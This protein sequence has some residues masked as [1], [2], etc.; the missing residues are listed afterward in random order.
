MASGER[1]GA[2]VALLSMFASGCLAVAKVTIGLY[3]GSTAVVA[4][5]VESASDVLASGI[6]IFGLTLASRPADENHPY[7]HGR[8][9]T[10]TGL[11]LGVILAVT[12]LLIC[13]RSAAA[14]R[15]VRPPPASFVVWPLIASILVKF[16]LSRLKF[17]T[18]ARIRSA[19]LRADAWN[20]SVD[21]LSAFS[22]LIAVGLTIYDPLR[23][24]AADHY[25]GFVIGA[26]VIFLG[27][28]VVRETSLQLVD[29][30][31]D[32]ETMRHIRQVAQTVPGALAVEK[33]FA[34]KTGLKYHVDLHL[35][36]DPELTVRESHEIAT[37]VRYRIIQEL[38]W[39][40][41]VLV[42]VEPFTP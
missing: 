38:R 40:A 18:A 31:P 10:L 14:L 3:A 30:M 20:D 4:D 21:I 27:L 1:L 26:L 7:G 11:G 16:W 37:Q 17:R 6:V 41:D 15:E 23:F 39:V 34:R 13:L 24:H 25:G 9:E 33:C 22:A 42:H 19:A 28:R 36:V 8:F 35:E 2:R 12:G 29:T 32:E 5:G